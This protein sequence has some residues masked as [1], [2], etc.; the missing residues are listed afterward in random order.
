MKKKDASAVDQIHEEH[1][2][3]LCEVAPQLG[4]KVRVEQGTFRS[5]KCRRR[6][7]DFIILNR[8][9]SPEDRVIVLATL[10]AAEDLESHFIKPD[11]RALIEEHALV[12]QAADGASA[13]DA[14]HDD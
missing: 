12:R 10:L 7:E 8:R 4:L 1:F 2:R 6:D 14:S 9:L 3:Q 11:M 13:E 5:G